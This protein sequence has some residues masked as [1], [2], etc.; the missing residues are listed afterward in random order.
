MNQLLP[1]ILDRAPYLRIFL[2]RPGDFVA[3]IVRFRC[4]AVTISFKYF[5]NTILADLYVYFNS[6]TLLSMERTPLWT[7][8]LRCLQI[9]A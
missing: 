9:S 3:R 4:V 8:L 5:L 6:I 2:S 1:A 7:W